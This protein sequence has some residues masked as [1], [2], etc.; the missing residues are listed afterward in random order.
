MPTVRAP[1]HNFLCVGKH[2]WP[3]TTTHHQAVG[4]VARQEYGTTL[5]NTFHFFFKW[6]TSIY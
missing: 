4:K 2:E 5:R 6:H 3:P 1:L